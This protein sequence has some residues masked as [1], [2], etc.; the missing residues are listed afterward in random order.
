MNKT[1]LPSSRRVR[2]TTLALLVA[3]SVMIAVP[4]LSQAA[5]SASGRA[6]SQSAAYD[7]ALHYM[8]RF[9]PRWFTYKQARTVNRLIAP[10]RVTP[11]YKAVVAINDDTLYGSGFVD[12]SSQPVIL[13][14]PSTTVTYSLLVLDAY[15][16]I[17][18][19]NIAPQT[20]GVYAFT[21]P[22]WT[23]TL[24]A[25]VTQ[26]PISVSFANVIIRADKYQGSVDTTQAA[27]EF[28][29]ALRMQP[30]SDYAADPAGGATRILPVRYFSVSYKQIA[31]TETSKTPIVF[32]KQLQEAMH[33]PLTPPLSG[34]DARLASRFDASFHD[35]DVMSPAV[36][37]Q[38]A[39]AVRAAHALIIA[40]YH[41]HTIG[42]DWVTFTNIGTWDHQYLDRDAIT[43]YIQY[44]NGRSTAAYYQTFKDREGAQL[45]G[46]NGRGYLLTFRKGEIPQAKRFW[47]VTAYVPATIELVPNRARKYVVAS[48]TPR[49]KTNP[50]GSISIYMTPTRPA[51]VRAAN[52]LPVPPGR[53]NIMLRVYG[54]QGRVANNTYLPPAI[55]S[56]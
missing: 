19:T 43:E 41:S 3:G 35:G 5:S 45:S 42:R 1:L 50:N 49:L 20:P 39:R 48:Y 8:V 51:G 16:N 53:F 13:T 11:V 34:S 40:R 38:F 52:W 25:G 10:R 9:Y 56:R 30:L 32:L 7:T 36:K 31:D 29:S 15:G 33:D 47:S 14:I 46:A 12:L 26:V 55:D 4:T 2:V 22:G 27:D 24:P 37:A 6:A 54:P 44:G 18:T 28:R 21:A 23:G 17:V